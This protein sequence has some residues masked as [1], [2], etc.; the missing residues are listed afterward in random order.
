MFSI[1]LVL[2]AGRYLMLWHRD[3]EEEAVCVILWGLCSLRWWLSQARFPGFAWRAFWRE[4]TAK[5]EGVGSHEYQRLI[6]D[7]LVFCVTSLPCFSFLRS[8][9]FADG[10]S[11]EL[12]R[13]DEVVVVGWVA[14][15]RCLESRHMYAPLET[16]NG[17]PACSR[18]HYSNLLRT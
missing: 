11:A 13:G 7:V 18:A 3:E 2:F 1:F 5:E 17:L 6:D 4:R 12:R 14:R 15:M 10:F 9:F 16:R 8:C